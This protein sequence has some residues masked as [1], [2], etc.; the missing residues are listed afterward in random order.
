MLFVTADDAQLLQLSLK[1]KRLLPSAFTVEIKIS[2]QA[3]WTAWELEIQ[4]S[5]ICLTDV[6]RLKR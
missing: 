4:L 1:R 6:I 2:P 5:T 3:L